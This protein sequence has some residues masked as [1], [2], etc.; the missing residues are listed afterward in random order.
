M[1][2]VIIAGTRTF[3][4][5]YFLKNVLNE[6]YPKPIIVVCGGASGAD[7]FGRLWAIKKGYPYEMFWAQ[8]DKEGK[9][10]GY[11]RNVKMG[12]F[13]DELVAFWDR[14]SKGTEHMIKIMEEKGKPVKIVYYEE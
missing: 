5:Y 12:E 13:A 14:K 3:D 4:D 9:K 11:N 2:K 10:A 6:L 8:W 7:N 1:K